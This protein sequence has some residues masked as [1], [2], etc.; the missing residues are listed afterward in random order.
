[1]RQVK[2]FC[3]ICSGTCGTVVTIDDE[4]RIH[5]VRGDK[6]HALTAGYACGKGLAVA[7]MHN[8]PDRILRPLKRR[9]DGTF[10]EISLEQATAEIAQRLSTLIA[11][12]GAQS[13]ATYCGTAGTWNMTLMKMVAP[14]MRAIGSPNVYTC[15]TIDC[16]SRVV[17][18]VRLGNWAAGKQ[19]W[20][21]SDVWMMFGTNPMLSITSIAGIPPLN[22]NKRMK[23]GRASGLKLIVVD[24]RRTETAAAADIHARIRPGEDIALIAGM[25]RIIIDE[26]LHDADFCARHVDGLDALR[27][28]VDPFTPDYVAARA[29]MTAE[30]VTTLAREFGGADKRGCATAGSGL[31]MSPFSNLADHMIELLN[32]V[33]GRYARAGEP[34]TNPVPIA[35]ARP[36]EAKVVRLPRWWE[37]GY[38]TRADGYG[39]LFTDEGGELPTSALPDEILQEGPGQIRALFSIGGNPASVFPDQHRTV[40]ALKSLDLLVVIDP[41]MT[42]TARMADYIIPPR[43]MYERVDIPLTTWQQFRIPVPFSQYTPALVEP[44][45]GADVTEEWHFFWDLARRLNRQIVFQ[46][47]PLDMETAPSSDELIDLM[48]QGAQIPMDEI[49][50]YPGGKVFAMQETVR[51]PAPDHADRFDVL[52]DDVAAELADYLGRAPEPGYDFLLT[53]RRM[54][55]IHNSVVMGRKGATHNPA[56]LHSADTAALGVA[57]GDM[58]RISSPAGDVTALIAVDDTLSPGTV[59]ISHGRGGLPGDPVDMLRDGTSTSKLVSLARN[60]ERINGMPAMT[61]IPVRIERC[62]RQG[63]SI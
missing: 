20:D 42:N 44:P 18:A 5:A 19:R 9:D 58:V 39:M 34:V 47:V 45:A 49:R 33:C 48:T 46:G 7:D 12:D 3:R 23:T 43:L 28:A 51:E 2:S 22:V 61:A 4:D 31:T 62:E 56:Y 8:R 35:P 36:T 29:G 17:T 60:R 26:G 1:M 52:P 32:V 63:A 10:E 37:D 27:A 54:R 16:S 55:G 53:T 15:L 13:I 50:R 40:E 6:E 59:S 41:L 21:G 38:K 14:F 24:P 30:A 11:R 25:L 57:P